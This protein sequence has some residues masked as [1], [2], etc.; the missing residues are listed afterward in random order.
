M[1]SM[2]AWA[3]MTASSGFVPE[4]NSSKNPVYYNTPNIIIPNPHNN[5][6]K[7]S[8][9]KIYYNPVPN[10]TSSPAYQS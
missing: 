4:Y 10:S 5:D 3:L 9:N 8:D 7:I 6:A 1:K 2:N